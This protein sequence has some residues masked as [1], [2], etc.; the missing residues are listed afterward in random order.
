MID[1]N[2]DELKAALKKRKTQNAVE[3][4][5]R[6][7]LVDEIVISYEGKYAPIIPVHNGVIVARTGSGKTHAFENKPNVLILVPRVLQSTILT[8]DNTDYLLDKILDSGAIITFDKFYGHYRS[9]EEFKSAVDNKV[10]T[11]VVDEAHMLVANPSRKNKLIYELDAVFMSGTIEKFFR[12]DLQ[13][14]KYKPNTSEV[15]YYTDGILP[16]IPNSLIFC[17][18]A[19]ALMTNYPK[20]CVVSKT[21]KD[22]Q[23]ENV[24]STT[25]MPILSTSALREGINIHNPIFKACMVY[26][27]A[28]RT[29][30]TKDII[31]ALHRIRTDGI[32]KIVSSP[33]KEQYKKKTNIKWWTDRAKSLMGN[34][35]GINGIFGEKYSK[36]IKTSSRTSGYI[37]PSEYGIACFLA[38]KTKNNYDS[39]FY[40]FAP[41]ELDADPMPIDLDTNGAGEEEE[42]IESSTLS[43]GS[44]WL[45]PKKKESKFKSWA[46]H[47][48]SGMVAKMMK[49]K[50]WKSLKYLYTKTKLAKEIKERYNRENGW[51][52]EKYSSDMFLKLLRE[53]VEVEMRDENGENVE[54]IG[55]KTF[56][57]KLEIRVT[58]AYPFEWLKLG[59]ND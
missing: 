41:Y 43:D 30:S 16:N 8:G 28:C 45:Y 13:R 38:D 5:A 51:K 58:K 11:I 17:D 20:N 6:G 4:I 42:E 55:S 57:T 12:P 3:K 7:E 22:H 46:V 35:A 40:Q 29:W 10:F 15:L 2:I 21:H 36:L 47:Y 37:E 33:P 59:E 18:N 32:I 27:T 31:Q 34:D 54:R 39:D 53:V 44:K 25:R 19:K 23:C 9:S 14:Y 49:V 56:L 52:G 26:M 1:I 50:E 24:H 48:E